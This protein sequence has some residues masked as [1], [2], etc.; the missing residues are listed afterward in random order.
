V[1]GGRNE[2]IR[3]EPPP[4]C[5]RAALLPAKA[6]YVGFVGLSWSGSK[7]VFPKTQK[8]FVFK[9][10]IFARDWFAG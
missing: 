1:S 8:W 3:T 10:R 7:G 2:V 5:T 9:C 6:R 4:D